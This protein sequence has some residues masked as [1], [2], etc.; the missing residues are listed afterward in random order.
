MIQANVKKF[1]VPVFMG[2][3][4]CCDFLTIREKA[5]FYN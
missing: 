5:G 4:D 1:Q 3:E 2:V